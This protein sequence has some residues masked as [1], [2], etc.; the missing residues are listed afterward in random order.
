MSETPT[1]YDFC[2]AWNW[3]YDGDFVAI[4]A[5]AC[6]KRNLSFLQAT[7]D[8]LEEIARGL[9]ENLLFVRVFLDRAAE[10]DPRYLI[11]DAWAREHALYRIDPFEQASRTWDKATMHAALIGAGLQTPHTI[12]LPSWQEQPSLEPA[13]LTPL[14]EKFTI[15]PAHGS[16]GVGVILE[17]TSWEQALAARRNN[18]ADRYLLQ[19][20]VAPV[21]LGGKPAWFRVLFCCGAVFPC[22]WNTATH[23]YIPVSPEEESAFNLQPLRRIAFELAR[24]C[25]LDS[26]STEIALTP[27][28]LFT[29]VDYIND[30]IDLRLQS[31]A[32]DGVP[33]A[34]VHD[35]A[36]RLA[37]LAARKC[38]PPPPPVPV[39]HPPPPESAPLPQPTPPPAPEPPP[40][41]P[42]LAP[43]PLPP[44]VMPESV[45]P[46]VPSPPP[47]EPPS[48]ESPPP[49]SI[50]T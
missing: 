44:A 3:E 30:Q 28:G 5:E 2:L 6:R 11:L 34:I 9:D 41:A 38:A 32:L 48:P 33:D 42:P 7:P 40:A 46:R 37:D 17:A 19:A 14:G 36:D 21:V 49:V 10:A 47:P 23:A 39:S 35:V 31:K 15:K 29:V 50:S 1:I 8:K 24:I 43:A 45:P 12:I 13:D 26:F 27:W 25:G 18:P 16:G 22:W 4:L 20:H